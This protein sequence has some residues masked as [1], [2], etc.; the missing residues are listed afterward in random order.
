[1]D[2]VNSETQIHQNHTF[3]CVKTVGFNSRLVLILNQC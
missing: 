2:N 3:G 1:M